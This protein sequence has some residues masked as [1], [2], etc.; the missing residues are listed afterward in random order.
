MFEFLVVRPERYD[1]QH[2]KSC[3]RGSKPTGQELRE[4]RIPTRAVFLACHM[5]VQW[6]TFVHSPQ[7]GSILAAPVIGMKAA[8]PDATQR[9]LTHLTSLTADSNS[10]D[11]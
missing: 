10:P 7:T 1:N 2:Y 11:G 3:A 6:T 9:A 4:G 5:A 8:F